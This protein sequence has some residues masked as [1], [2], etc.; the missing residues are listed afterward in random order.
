MDEAHSFGVFG[1]TGAGLCEEVAVKADVLM[2][3]FGKATASSGACVLGSSQL[4]TWLWNRAR[5]FV[6]STAPSPRQ[7][8][9]LYDNLQRLRSDAKRRQRLTEIAN[10][11][12]SSLSDAG[13]QLTG[14]GPILSLIFGEEQLALQAARDLSEQGIVAQA[15]RPPTVPAGASRLRVTMKANWQLRQVERLSEA[16]IQQ[17]KKASICSSPDQ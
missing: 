4:R 2:C 12:R 16:L 10:Q 9:D 15:I 3:G 11:V 14:H 6:F 8:H 1:P 5:S 13:L 7:V 17:A